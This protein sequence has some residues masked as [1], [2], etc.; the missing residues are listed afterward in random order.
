MRRI[1]DISLAVRGGGL[2]YPGDPDTTITS[3]QAIA[4]GATANV[5]VVAFSSHTATHVDA[6][7]H[8]IDGAQPVDEIPLSR[9]IGRARVLEFSD[10]LTAI[11]EPELRA[12]HLGG[13]RRVLLKTRNSVLL[14]S[15]DFVVGHAYLA[16]DGARYLVD[17]G[18]ELV[19]IDYLSIERFDAA[20]PLTHLTL[21]EREVVI[22]EGLDLSR[23]NAGTYQLVCLP[24]KLAGLDGAPARVVL[25]EDEE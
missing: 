23:V 15:P 6:A 21:L 4:R 10:A 3:H 1:H 25:L 11:G 2:H 13:A 17:Q 20:E 19:G 12:Q 7:R 22:V 16:P 24:L 9:L 14:H 18:V 8:F 5:S